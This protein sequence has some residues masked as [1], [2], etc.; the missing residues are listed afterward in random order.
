MKTKLMYNL[1]SDLF[2]KVA[3]LDVGWFNN[4]RKGDILSSISNDV[5]EVQNSI[6]GSFHIFF[7]EPLLVLG[8]LAA[9]FFMSPKL[10]IVSLVALPLSAI[11]ISKITGRLR[12]DAVETQTLMGRILSHF[13]EAIS[14]SRPRQ[15]CRRA[16]RQGQ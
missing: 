15:A 13:E 4:R 12:R 16:I 1:R 10:T 9:L 7:R 11:V 8:F 6:A 2:R 14:G 5:A 3:S